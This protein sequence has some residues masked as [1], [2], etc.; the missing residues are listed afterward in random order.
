VSE[1]REIIALSSVQAF[2]QGVKFERERII[3]VLRRTLE[4]SQ[5]TQTLIETVLP[6]TIEV[7]E[8]GAQ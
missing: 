5:G 3:E 1:L 2:N 7:I 6:H 4:I 8:G